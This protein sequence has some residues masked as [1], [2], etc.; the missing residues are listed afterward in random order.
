MV[1]TKNVVEKIGDVLFMH[2]GIS[3]RLNGLPVTVNEINQL[4]RPYYAEKKADYDDEK[5]NVILSPSLSPFWYRGYYHNNRSLKQ[6][7]ID[8]T[9][10]KFDVSRIITGHTIVTGY[11]Q[12]SPGGQGD[13]Y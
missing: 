3:P 1:M 6:K 11:H 8:S 13:K 10:C 7:Q 12:R 5:L 9:L 2:A 4:A